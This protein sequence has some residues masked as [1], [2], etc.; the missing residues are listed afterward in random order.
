M[1]VGESLLGVLIA[2]LV[3][4]T[5]KA[6]PFALVGAGFTDA[7]VWLGG[8]VFVAAAVALYRWLNRVSGPAANGRAAT[9]A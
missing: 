1:I 8:G 3:V 5:D 4:V 6:T 2:G 7:A 9:R